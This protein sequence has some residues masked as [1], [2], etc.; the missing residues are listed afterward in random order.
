MSKLR[1]N[2][3]TNGNLTILDLAGQLTAGHGARTLSQKLRRLDING[4][5]N[6]LVNLS[7]VT[8]L[9]EAG[10]AVLGD[11][12]QNRVREDNRLKLFGVD[13]LRQRMTTK[14][15]TLTHLLTF[16]DVFDD[17]SAAVLS[18]DRQA[19]ERRARTAITRNDH[20]VAVAAAEAYDNEGGSIVATLSPSLSA[21]G[22]KNAR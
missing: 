16:F 14:L 21:I 7:R 6:V 8:G 22:G 12:R 5:N 4:E 17:E 10:M 3:R 13:R 1:I 20:V 15:L 11:S 2:T 18:F 9:D 19:G